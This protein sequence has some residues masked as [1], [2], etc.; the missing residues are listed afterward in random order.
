MLSKPRIVVFLRCRINPLIERVA[1]T[2][3]RTFCHKIVLFISEAFKIQRKHSLHLMKTS[4]WR[5]MTAASLVAAFSSA[6]ADLLVRYDFENTT[7]TNVPNLAAGSPVSNGTLGNI[8]QTSLSLENTVIVGGVTRSL[9]TAMIFAPASD[10]ADGAN[11]GNVD[12]GATST[13]LNI[14]PTSNYTAMAWAKFAS[15]AGDNMI[16]GQSASPFLHLGSRNGDYHSG[17]YGDDL[18]PDQGVHIPTGRGAW[19]HVAFVNN[20]QHQQIFIDGVLRAEGADNAGQMSLSDNVLIGTSL[21]G[22]SFAGTLDE[23][24]IYNAALSQSDIQTAM[25]DLPVV[26]VLSLDST[27]ATPTS[28]ILTISD[29]VS[30]LDSNG[31]YSVTVNGTTVPAG[32]L[33]LTKNGNTTTI[34]INQVADPNTYYNISATVTRTDALTQTLTG[35]VLSYQLPIAPA[36]LAGS[37]GTWG[38]REYRPGSFSRNFQGA[39]DIA[40]AGTETNLEAP[41]PVLNASDPDTATPRLRGNFNNDLPFITNNP[42]VDDNDIV[43][44]AK[45][46]VVINAAGDYTFSVHSDEGFAMRVSGAAGGRFI[47]KNGVGII[48]PN[49][50]QTL[51][52]DQ[53]TSDS[54]TRGTYHFDG[55]GTYSI[56]YLGWESATNGMVEVAWAPGVFNEDKDTNTWTLVGTPTDPS[57]PGFSPRFYDETQ[58]PSDNVLIPGLAGGDTTWGVRVFHNAASVDNLY[59]AMS[60]LNNPAA[61]GQAT[62]LDAAPHVINFKDPDSHAGNTGIIPSDETFPGDVSGDTDRVIMVAHAKMKITET[63]IYTFNVRGDDGFLFRFKTPGDTILRVAGGGRFEMSNPNEAFFDTGTGDSDTRIIISLTAGIHEIEY[64]Y[65]EGTG[66]HWNE[67]SAAKGSFPGNGDTNQWR[68]VG[69]PDPGA[70]VI[71]IVD[72]NGWTVAASAPNF[73]GSFNIA[74]A[75]AAVSGAPTSNW[76]QINFAD[77]QNDGG[78]NAGS[79]G[80]NSDWPGNTGVDDDNYAMRAQGNILITEEG[81]YTLGFRGD[82]GGYMII[83]GIGANP[84]PAFTKILINLTG[85]SVIQNDGAGGINNMIRCEVGTGD[86]YTMAQVHLLP[87]TYHMDNLFYEGG[88]GSFWEVLCGRLLPGGVLYNTTRAALLAKTPNTAVLDSPGIQLTSGIAPLVTEFIKTPTGAFSITFTSETGAFYT[89]EASDSLLQGTW[90]SITDSIIGSSGTTTFT[91]VASQ[92]FYYDS[93]LNRQF[94][95]IRKNN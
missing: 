43:I 59:Q 11:V 73:L 25:A 79:W 46:Q 10:A 58:T 17:H 33:S 57:I 82:D 56:L 35:S 29:H 7:S 22:G 24:R 81:E 61:M 37:P 16:F 53:N 9:G 38:I 30:V 77:P 13:A 28:S 72:A 18:G 70:Q 12:T 68:L 60:F 27:R 45:T 90:E 19:H 63:G 32:L 80:N 75:L 48:D 41:R 62:V 51:I 36:G 20:G 47:S 54:N 71:P 69:F 1:I 85:Q 87:G 5:F 50:D 74:G 4:L 94:Y 44:V 42:G 88:G 3:M 55:A 40:S 23:V 65:W 14:T 92:Y 49:D 93:V 6:R 15:I 78:P 83:T 34:T 86:S 8:A 21:N 26:S 95:R 52:M 84:T 76:D 31:P 64:V 91:G 67:I 2:R 39:E 66:G 89:L